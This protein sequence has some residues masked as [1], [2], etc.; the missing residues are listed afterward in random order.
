M[1]SVSFLEKNVTDAIKGM[2]ILLV[3]TMHILPM[4]DTLLPHELVRFL[5]PTGGIG[6]AI[7]LFLSGYGIQESYK[8]TGLNRY[9]QKRILKVVIPWALFKIIL[10]LLHPTDIVGAPYRN[11]ISGIQTGGYFEDFILDIACLKTPYWWYI[12]FAM[13]WYVIYWVSR[14]YLGK[15]GD[16]FML[17]YAIA[18]F[19][20]IENLKS[21]QCLS[22]LFGV[23][24]SANKQKI[25]AVIT[26]KLLYWSLGITIAAFFALIIKQLPS[27]RGFETES[28]IMKTVELMIKLPLGL[29]VVGAMQYLFPYQNTLIC[30][31]L[32]SLLFF[33]GII[34]YELYIIHM[35]VLRFLND[36]AWNIVILLVV[37]Y[38][39]AYAY[40][41]FSKKIT[42]SIKTILT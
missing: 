42:D 33:T 23:L 21:Q 32:W 25:T 22:F 3:I 24:T 16:V 7:F 5:T 19:F 41:H 13:K 29:G 9:W 11:E 38:H 30:R 15:Y 12:G 36:W 31:K 4:L 39:L 8:K 26:P 40:N 35:E 17:G 20:T 28:V 37:S 34:S 18:M 10:L 14:R 6:V 27:I 1:K 2:A